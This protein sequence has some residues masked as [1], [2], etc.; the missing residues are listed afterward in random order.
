[1]VSDR[2]DTPFILVGGGGHATVCLDLLLRQNIRIIG[3]IS[4]EPSSHINAVPYL[5]EDEQM[6]AFAP[7]EVQLVMGVGFIVGSSLREVLFNRY[8]SKG[9]QF[10]TLIHDAAIVSTSVKVSEG[11]Q[12]MAGAVV[13]TDA[14]IGQN[15]LINTRASVDHG[16]CIGDHAA[17]M[18]GTTICGDVNV[19]E[20]VYVGAGAT[21]L[22]NLTIGER[23][24]V[25]AGAVVIN[26]LAS[27]SFVYGVPATERKRERHNDPC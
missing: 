4:K 16:S 24:V 26:S 11:A 7:N 27:H 13:Q 15:A 14:V 22:P 1:M 19:A 18:P 3:Y 12:I 10:A 20:S 25:G 21:I 6:Q 9:Y 8:K 23:S 2:V 17:L 5:G